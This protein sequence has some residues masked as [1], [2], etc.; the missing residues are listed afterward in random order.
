MLKYIYLNTIALLFFHLCPY[1]RGTLKEVEEQ[2]PSINNHKFTTDTRLVT[3]MIPHNRPKA[4]H[5][6]LKCEG[7]VKKVKTHNQ[8][9]TQPKRLLWTHTIWPTAVIMTAGVL[10]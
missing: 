10:L 5:P 9:Q 6:L 1:R 8:Q 3:F 2:I 4:N 7:K